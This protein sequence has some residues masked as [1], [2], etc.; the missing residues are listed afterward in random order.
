MNNELPEGKAQA[1]KIKR[2]APRCVLLKNIL[3][4]RSFEGPLL[5]CLSEKEVDYVLREIHEGCCAEHLG[6]ISLARNSMLAGFWWLTLIQ[7]SA[8]VVQTCE[9][10]QH[11]SNFQHIPA[12]LMKPIWASFS[13]DQWGMDIVGPIPI[14]RAQKKF[15]LVAVIIFPNG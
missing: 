1:Q 13:F 15:L 5:K 4:K 2:Q 8:R 3:Y 9:G 10:C 11:H 12:T 14:S 6:G 7:D